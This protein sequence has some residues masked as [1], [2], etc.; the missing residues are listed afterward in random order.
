MFLW[1]HCAYAGPL[2]LQRP[3]SSRGHTHFS[4]VGKH[5][6]HH[7]HHGMF[8]FQKKRKKK[9]YVKKKKRKRKNEKKVLLF[10]MCMPFFSGYPR[11][12]SSSLE[13]AN[14][15]IATKEVTRR[16]FTCSFFREDITPLIRLSTS[17]TGQNLD[18]FR[19]TYGHILHMLT[20]RI[21]EWALY[22]LL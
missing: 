17:V 5:P 21:D 14:N 19:K 4:Y 10:L 16:T 15:V 11:L 8:T 6:S 12:L 18:E 9:R 1:F 3:I 7:L 2:I 22:T 20:S 13:M